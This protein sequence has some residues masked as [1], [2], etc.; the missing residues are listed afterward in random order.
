VCLSLAS[1]ALHRS[2]V[3]AKA[4]SCGFLHTLC[5]TASGEVW[6]WGAGDM[7]QVLAGTLLR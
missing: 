7:G 3:V 4:I 6:S 1:F 2:V 5:L